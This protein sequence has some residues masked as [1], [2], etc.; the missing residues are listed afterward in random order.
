LVADRS[1][2]PLI[3]QFVPLKITTS[4]P[5]WGKINKRYP[6]PGNTIPVVYVI[7]ADGKKIYA[8]RSTL[9][10]N[11]LP[12]VLQLSL[13]QAG[14]MLN[15]TQ[16]RMVI[17]SVSAAKTALTADDPYAATLAIK[18]LAKFGML[19]QLQSFAKPIMD[20]NAVVEELVNRGQADLKQIAVSLENEETQF[21]GALQLF[22]GVRTYSFSLPLKKE[23][24]IALRDASSNT[25]LEQTLVQAR[26]ID[27]ARTLVYI[28]GGKPKAIEALNKLAVQ[29][30]G[31]EGAG[32]VA[33]QLQKIA[34][35]APMPN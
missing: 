17:Q 27:K 31:T 21:A 12:N 30:E 23:F 1:L 16:A 34:T 9:S 29:Y 33:E 25:E 22:A 11:Q 28:R 2:A 15:D 7:R 19:G 10:G 5:D 18:P 4:S 32:V 8:D 14:G 26:A 13:R 35:S 24:A 6:L 3:A 20:A